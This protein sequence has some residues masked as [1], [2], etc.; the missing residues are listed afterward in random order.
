MKINPIQL[1]D[2]YK[3]GHVFQYPEGTEYVYSNWTPRMSR[4]DGVD[5]VVFF[6]LQYFM[7]EYLNNQFDTNFFN[8]SLESVISE[9]KGRMFGYLGCDLPSYDHIVALHK[10]GYLPLRIK[11]LP[12]GSRVNLRV[13]CVTIQ[14]TLPEFYWLTNFI[15]SLM[16]N[17]LWMP[18]TS[19]TIANTYRKI[20]DKYAEETSDSPFLVDYQGHDFSFRGMAG[21]EAA[22]MSGA[23]HLLSFKGTDTIPAISFLEDYYGAPK[24]NMDVGCSVAATEHSVMCAG[25]PEKELE[26][27]KRLVTE[28]YPSGIVSIVSDQ[29]DL[30][31]V[32][33]DYVKELKP[34]IMAR[35]GKVVFRPDSGDPVRILCGDRLDLMYK[36][37]ESKGVIQLLWETFGGTINSKG[38]K[39]LDPHVGAIYGD[40]ISIDRAKTICQR[41]KDKGF[42]STNVVFGIGSY[43]YQHNTRDTFGFALKSTYVQ[44]NGKGIDI[45]KDPVTDDG[46][47]K[48]AVGLVKVVKEE[49]GFKLIDG[50][51]SEEEE[52]GELKTVFLNGVIV[53]KSRYSEV[54]KNLKNC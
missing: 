33:T 24:Y 12:E 43:T 32:M 11:A 54:I 22:C 30:W 3:T 25:T 18:C 17:I 6:G 14:N 21:V 37:P 8:R 2:G 39:E 51:S 29:Y 53:R 50:V 4:I 23:G 9:Y 46:V 26:T 49:D 1:T 5:K 48:S 38:Y 52:T 31:K 44:I 27:F 36:T 15:E 34:Y 45:F 10:L 42:A 19:A 16:S 13:P 7:Q 47:K 40:S 35:D 20:F 41:L 28:V